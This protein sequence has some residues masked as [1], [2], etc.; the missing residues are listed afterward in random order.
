MSSRIKIA[1]VQMEPKLMKSR[2][3][4]GRSLSAAKE[5]AEKHADLIIS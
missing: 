5:A 4:L 3:N 2:E 1:V